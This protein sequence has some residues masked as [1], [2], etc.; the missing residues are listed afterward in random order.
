MFIAIGHRCQVSWQNVSGWALPVSLNS[1]QFQEADVHVV[2][3]GEARAD[4]QRTWGHKTF[5]SMFS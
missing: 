3:G 2:V 4:G 5:V 1:K